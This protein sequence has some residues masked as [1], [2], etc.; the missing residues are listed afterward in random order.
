MLRIVSH[1]SFKILAWID[2]KLLY[3]YLKGTKTF[4]LRLGG[5]SSNCKAYSDAYWA[6]DLHDQ[7]S[8]PGYVSKLGVGPLLWGSRKQCTVLLSSTEAEYMAMSDS[9]CEACWI[10]S[11][12]EGLHISDQQPI[13]LC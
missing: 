3:G 4:K 6:K 8:S 9:C 2:R 7:K 5:Q 1:K 12:L 13:I 10:A 11:L